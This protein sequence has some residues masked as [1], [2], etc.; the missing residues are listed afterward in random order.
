VSRYFLTRVKVEGFRGINN[1]DQPLELRFKPESVNSVFAA[2]AS[3]KSSIFEALCFAIKGHVPKLRH[4]QAGEEPDKY[5]SNLFHS[6]KT[7]VVEL[8]LQDEAGDVSGPRQ[9]HVMP[10]IRSDLAGSRAVQRV[11]EAMLV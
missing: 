3:G 5:I 10:R 7:A 9:S 2:N 8:E 6:K 11:A 1:E 4:L